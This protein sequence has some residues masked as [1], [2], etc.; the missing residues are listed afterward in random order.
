MGTISVLYPQYFKGKLHLKMLKMAGIAGQ[1]PPQVLAVNELN[2][3]YQ[4]E[5]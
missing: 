5:L 4:T 2:E 3:C 1:P